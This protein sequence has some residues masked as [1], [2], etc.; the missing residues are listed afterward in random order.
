MLRQRSRP[1]LFSN[2]LSP[3]IVLTTIQVIDMLSETTALRDKLE[4]NTLYFR[5]EMTKRGFEIKPGTHPICPIMLYDAKLAQEFAR[6]LYYEGIYVIGFFYPV[7]PKG[8]ARI[9]VQISAAH[10]TEH[11]D[12]AIEAFTKIGKRHSI[13]K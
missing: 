3:I 5:K 9:R 2:T 12:K 10:E 8:Q 4:Q 7:V 11:I 13:I 1:Y 6:D